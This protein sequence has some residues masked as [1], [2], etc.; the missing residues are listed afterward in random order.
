VNPP[1]NMKKWGSAAVDKDSRWAYGETPDQ[2]AN[3]AWI[4]PLVHRPQRVSGR[5]RWFVSIQVEPAL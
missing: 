4:L 5:A 3:Y 1:F 2:N